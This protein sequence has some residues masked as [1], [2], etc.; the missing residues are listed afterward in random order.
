MNEELEKT[1]AVLPP[2]HGDWFKDDNSRV[3]PLDPG[4][5][6]RS[7]V[8]RVYSSDGVRIRAG[9]YGDARATMGANLISDD[10]HW[11]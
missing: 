8:R 3:A 1:V 6:V 2:P 4:I 11:L 7:R 5:F 10:I 9:W